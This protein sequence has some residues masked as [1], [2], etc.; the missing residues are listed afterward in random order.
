MQDDTLTVDAAMNK[1]KVYRLEDHLED[2]E[3]RYNSVINRLDTMDQRMER[4][5]D[6]LIEIKNRLGGAR[7]ITTHKLLPR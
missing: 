1:A 3:E 6:I 4:M 7:P 2:C 5:E